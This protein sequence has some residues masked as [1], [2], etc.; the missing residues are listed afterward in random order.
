MTLARRRLGRTGLEVSVMGLGSGGPSRLGQRH[1]ANPESVQHLV[2]T[3]LELGINMI[4]TSPAY[5]SSESLLGEALQGVDR[6]RY[7]LSTKFVPFD[8]DDRLRPKD[9]LRRS[10]ETSLERLGTDHVDILYFHSVP[11]GSLDA[12]WEVFGE[13]LQ[14]TVNNDLARFTGVS[15]QYFADHE[16]QTVRDALDRYDFDVLMAGYNLLSPAAARAVF[17]RA[18]ARDVGI[19]VMCAVRGVIADNDKLEAVVRNWKRQGLLAD[20]DL[21]SERPLDW[22]LEEAPSIVAAAYRFAAAPSAVSSVLTGTASPNHLASNV[23]GISGP[24]LRSET[25]ERLW[26]VFG[27]VGRNVGP[28]DAAD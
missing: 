19:V 25:L 13:S 9:D 1:G 10:L 27:K 8:E 23:E 21:P 2:T 4:D 3:A 18:R 6:D 24:N 14:A 11:A 22:L 15:E 5:G 17:P 7:V 28:R 12:V 16:H 20:D 26:D